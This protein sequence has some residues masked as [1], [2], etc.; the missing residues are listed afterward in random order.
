MRI[1][2]IFSNIPTNLPEELFEAIVQ[3]PFCRVE[4]I[5]S[6]GHTTPADYWYDQEN[7]EWVILLE[8][9]ARLLF[10]SNSTELDMC[11]EDYVNIPA[12]CRHR[13]VYTD[14]NENTIWLAIHY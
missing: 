4:R 11:V 3:T 5:V 9:K 6:R 12:H 8:G 10:E 1:N 14:P 13:V 7:H 2:S